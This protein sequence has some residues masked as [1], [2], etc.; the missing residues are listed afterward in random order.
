MKITYENKRLEVEKGSTPLEVLKYEI[1]EVNAIACKVNNEVRALNYR[2]EE[3]AQVE[4][5]DITDQDGMRIYIRGILFVMAKAFDKL[6]PEAELDVNYQLH[7]SMFCEA[8]NINLTEEILQKVSEE[9]RRIISENIEIRK[10]IMTKEEAEI[11][12]KKEQTTRGKLQLEAKEQVS[13]Y[14][15][16]DYYNYFYG[17]MPVSTGILKIYELIKYQDGFLIRYPSRKMPN[18]L[19]K[20]NDTRKLSTTLNEYDDIHKILKVST[21]HNLNEIVRRGNAKDLILLDEA[22]HEKK[23]AAI[24]DK[25]ARNKNIKVVLIAGPSSSGKTTFAKRL[26][27]QL[28]LNGLKPVTISVDNY[29]VEREDTPR[30]EKGNYDFESINAIDIDLFN[31]HLIKLINGE[32][33]AVPTFNFKEGHKKYDGTKMSLAE[34]EILVIEGIHCLN[35]KL[36]EK[37]AKEQKYKIYISDL[38]ILNIDTFNRISTTDS[39]LI[40]RMVRDYKYRGYSA[41]H[42][43]KMWYSVNRGEEKNIFPFQE[44]A[45]SMFNS[46]LVYELAVLK[47]YAIPLLEEITK[48]KKEYSEAVRL[49]D[50]LRYFSSIPEDDIPKNSLLREFIGGSIFGE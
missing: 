50:L 36:T 28:R 49:R 30:D 13:L 22:L 26:G 6:F 45:D 32:E 9:M 34:D 21:V 31:T 27:I 16:E 24:A 7:N 42:T 14:Y 1:K 23:M 3:D 47:D 33:V 11:F 19:T 35:D 18:G 5:L 40:R 29:F 41:L 39:R 8:K 10:V 2:I 20:F 38:T 44:E 25:V 46:S 17:V 37:I 48:D 43:L 4:L 15:C 12:Y